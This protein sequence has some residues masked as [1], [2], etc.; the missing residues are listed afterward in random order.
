MGDDPSEELHRRR[1]DV[2]VAIDRAGRLLAATPRFHE[3]M[4]TSPDAV[5]GSALFE[6]PLD[7]RHLHP[8]LAFLHRVFTDGDAR[9]AIPIRFDLTSSPGSTVG[10][11]YWIASGRRVEGAD[12]PFAVVELADARDLIQASDVI[13]ADGGLGL[14]AA[15]LDETG[16]LVWW[17]DM[18]TG[19]VE[20]YGGRDT[21]LGI[22]YEA[23]PARWSW[24]Q[25]LD[26][27]HR[28]AFERA[29]EAH[30]VTGQGWDLRYPIT[31]D[32]GH[33]VRDRAKVV[34]QSGTVWLIGSVCLVPAP[35]TP[36]P[37]RRLE[38][39]G[40][41]AAEVVHDLKNHF[42][43]IVIA[44]DLAL[45][46]LDP[47]SATSSLLR[48]ISS[49]ARGGAELSEEILQL[50]RGDR[51]EHAPVSVAD[52]V[53]QTLRMLHVEGWTGIAVSV[54]A[55]RELPPVLGSAAD[56]RRVVQN[57]VQNARDAM[58]DG[59]RIDIR[60]SGSYV[61]PGIAT[62]SAVRLSVSDEGHGVPDDL[63]DR[64]FEPFF[65]TKRR[66]G[67]GLGLALSRRIV[68]SYGGSLTLDT[69]PNGSTFSVHLPL[70]RRL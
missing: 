1:V 5:S 2:A 6:A 70:N 37:A 42:A 29:L 57:L 46:Q 68:Q 38:Q 65:T 44:A 18:A 60:V 50:L 3:L 58:P 34:H 47:D 15:A 10:R 12:A 69:S 30:A 43:P 48:A 49:S 11:R 39:A 64:I 7:S 33:W 16:P 63:R 56:L 32:S 40:L 23:L 31:P 28:L 59:G 53:D 4:G 13:A 35:V 9:T 20:R 66:G 26:Q 25:H 14:V 21:P 41:L 45:Q 55:A 24:L 27:E 52:V 22:A 54:E 17:M 36:E 51:I 67:T 19:A 62:P 61:A 8:G